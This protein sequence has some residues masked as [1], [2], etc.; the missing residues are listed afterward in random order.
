M[1]LDDVRQAIRRQINA[2]LDFITGD[3]PS[4]VMSGDGSAEEAGRPRIIGCISGV[5]AYILVYRSCESRKISY[6]R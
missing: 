6:Y 1:A 3:M 5:C 4:C 2:N